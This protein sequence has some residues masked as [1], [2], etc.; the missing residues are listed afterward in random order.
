MIDRFAVDNFKSISGIDMPLGKFNCLVGMNGAGKSTLLQALDFAARQMTGDIEGWLAQRGWE[1]KDLS[2]KLRKEQNI[3]MGLWITL[4]QSGKVISWGFSFN[5]K[6]LRCTHEEFKDANGHVLF[7]S[8]G[9]SYS[10]HGSARRDIGF[11]YQGSILSQLK[12]SELP[13]DLLEFR[14]QI[15]R[16]KSLELLSPQ[17]LRKR[18]RAGETDIGAGGEKLSAYLH[19]IRG[20]QRASLIELLQLFYPALVD[21]KVTNLRA[22]WKRLSIIEQFGDTRVE[23]DASHINDGLLRILAVLAQTR[24]DRSLVLLDEIENGINPEIV[25]RLV[26]TLVSSSQQIIVTT[27]SPMILNYMSDDTARQ[28]VQFVYKS[29]LGATNV[30]RFFDIPRINEK[31]AFMGPGEAFVDTSLI[32]LTTEC[33]AEDV[34]KLEKA[35]ARVG[36]FGTKL[37][38]L[39]VKPKSAP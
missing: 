21:F 13:E 36:Q 14:E 19:G 7:L 30:R 23:T 3:K 2:C 32:Q 10:T 25:E 12:D 4:P 17:L 5:K 34:L 9:H 22:G 27:H 11:T 16:V 35:V 37:S 24:S 26:D 29:P 1:A 8:D 33:V 39:F 18:A 15:R 38:T 20:E 6:E 31:L 28:A